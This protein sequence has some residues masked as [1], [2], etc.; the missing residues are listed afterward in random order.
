M[1]NEW[2]DNEQ[3]GMT[4]NGDGK[5]DPAD[6]RVTLYCRTLPALAGRPPADRLPARYGVGGCFSPSGMPGLGRCEIVGG[7][8]QRHEA[9]RPQLGNPGNRV[10]R[11]IRR[12]VKA[13]PLGPILAHLVGERF[14]FALTIIVGLRPGSNEVF[15]CFSITDLGRG[16][17]LDRGWGGSYNCLLKPTNWCAVIRRAVTFLF[18]L[19]RTNA[20]AIGEGPD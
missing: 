12:T 7:S 5:T 14:V 9:H 4:A 6:T 1:P 3:R 2:S 15:L 19:P 13:T 18:P 16:G 11:S 8:G 10:Y 20:P 17:V